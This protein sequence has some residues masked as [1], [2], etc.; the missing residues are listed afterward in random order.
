[1]NLITTVLAWNKLSII[2]L[3]LQLDYVMLL[4][5]IDGDDL[6]QA[7]S[8]V[9]WG[10]HTNQCDRVG[11]LFVHGTIDWCLLYV[12]PYINVHNQFMAVCIYLLIS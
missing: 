11:Q 2:I 9:T 4:I 3:C 6:G 5:Y 1:M 10:L 12:L 8:I 7:P